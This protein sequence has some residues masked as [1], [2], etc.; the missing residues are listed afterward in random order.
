MHGCYY[1]LS[2]S[3]AKTFFKSKISIFSFIFSGLMHDVDHT[4]KNNEFMIKSHS[5]L[6]VLYNDKNV[7]GQ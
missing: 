6:A 1:L 3:H 2:H 7:R 5:K 4:G